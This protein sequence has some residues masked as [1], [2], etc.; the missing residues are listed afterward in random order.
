MEEK[1]LKEEVEAPVLKMKNEVANLCMG[2]DLITCETRTDYELLIKQDNVAAGFEKR[3][4]EYWDGTDENPGPIKKAHDLHK[5]L[6]LKRAEMLNPL[7]AF[8]QAVGRIT[9][10]WLALEQ[11][12]EQDRLDK[13]RREAEAIRAKQEAEL[14]AAADKLRKEQEAERLKKQIEFQNSPAELARQ[15][16]IL[17]VRQQEAQAQLERDAKAR[18]VDTAAIPMTAEKVEAGDGRASV[19]KWS[20]EI[21][22]ESL[23]PREY[24]ML[25]EKKI[26]K[27]VTAMKDKTNIPG[28]R[29]KKETSVRRTGR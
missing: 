20:W 13:L 9:G 18:M 12:R 15:N 19:E 3:V 25:D 16:E 1:S 4:T 27:V 28:I 7:K 14:K 5:V 29:V 6:T 22:D 2:A 8:R 17:R 26:N 23:V 21:V 11:R 10:G 24:L